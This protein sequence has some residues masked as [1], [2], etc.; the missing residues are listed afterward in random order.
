MKRIF[1]VQVACLML[2]VTSLTKSFV[3]QG[4]APP[5]PVEISYSSF[6]QLVERQRGVNA[7]PVMDRVRIG[8]DPIHYRLQHASDTDAATSSDGLLVELL[9]HSQGQATITLTTTERT[10]VSI[11]LHTPSCG[12]TQLAGTIV[13]QR[14]V[15]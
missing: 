15:L 8:S 12:A 5:P 3:T 9:T 11:G 1:A 10:A 2:L 4:S 6:L 13:Q 7:A 14:G